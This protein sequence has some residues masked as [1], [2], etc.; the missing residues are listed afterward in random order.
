MPTPPPTGPGTPGD[1][2]FD[3]ADLQVAIAK[4]RA[5]VM[6]VVFAMVG[7]IGLFLATVWLLIQGGTDVGKHLGLLGQYLPGY[8]VTW[9]GAFL[10]LVYGAVIGAVIGWLVSTIYNRIAARHD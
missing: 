9:G 2:S 3:A 7:G 8:R 6:A 5:S 4:M 1:E 10:G